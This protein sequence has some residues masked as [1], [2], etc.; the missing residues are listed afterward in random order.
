METVNEIGTTI[1]LLLG[2]IAGIS[3]F[4]GGIGVMNIMLVSVTER[5]RE[6]GIRRAIGATGP[7]IALQFLIE[8]LALSI[9]GGIAGILLGI[10]SS[11]LLNG[12]EI[13]ETPLI[14]IITPWS[15][16]LAFTVASVVGIVSGLYPAWRASLLDP[17]T[18]LRNQ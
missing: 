1:S 8:A 5:T 16:I 2:S 6:I 17:I 14:T 7:D 15:I 3:L 9:L 11:T 4:V 18:A 12:Y 10:T 13:A